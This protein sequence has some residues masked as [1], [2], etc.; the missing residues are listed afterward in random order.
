MGKAICRDSVQRN[1]GNN[2]IVTR[3]WK[4][5]SQL[6]VYIFSKQSNVNKWPGFSF[7]D[8]LWE[9]VCNYK[10]LELLCK[11]FLKSCFL[12]MSS[13]LRFYWGYCLF[14]GFLSLPDVLTNLW[15]L[16]LN[17]LTWDS[18]FWDEKSVCIFA[19]RAPGQIKYIGK[20]KFCLRI[21][22]RIHKVSPFSAIPFWSTTQCR[23][24]RSMRSSNSNLKTLDNSSRLS[25]A[26]CLGCV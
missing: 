23:F 17:F 18:F 8:R 25:R 19:P 11:Y 24:S 3:A 6:F 14:L 10:C 16:N 20:L 7:S 5:P 26:K 12:C 21:R 15:R 1:K 2:V 13:S 22:V 4:A 9:R